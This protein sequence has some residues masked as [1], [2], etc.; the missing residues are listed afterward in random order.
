MTA[1]DDIGSFVVVT[2]GPT[3]IVNCLPPVF[4]WK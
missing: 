3:R 4:F 1:W 2:Y